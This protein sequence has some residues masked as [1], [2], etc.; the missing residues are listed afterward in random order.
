MIL[1]WVLKYIELVLVL[2]LVG[3]GWQPFAPLLWAIPELLS[4]VINVFLFSILI[5]VVVSWINPGGY[6][7]ALSVIYT[8]TRPL[9]RPAQR[10]LPPI[11]GLDL[12][13][14]LVVIGLV[15]LQMLLLPPIR[16]LTGSPF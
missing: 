9:L 10:L 2:L 8:L 15:M 7:P 6:N 1:A 4:L 16:V 3:A 14:M 12:S 5:Q 11:G 13:P